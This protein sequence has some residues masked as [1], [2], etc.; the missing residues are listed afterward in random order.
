[1]KKTIFIGCCFLFLVTA[2]TE[3]KKTEDAVKPTTEFVSG[4]EVFKKSCVACHG[5]NGK[6]G[7]S[8]AKDLTK[9]T[10]PV[11][12]IKIQVTNGKG[13]MTGFKNLLTE[14]EILAVSNYAYEFRNKH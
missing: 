14:E 3:N 11:D 1:M 4:E 9:S 8:G 12:S 2:C 10:L 13:A 6:L 7:F 5:A